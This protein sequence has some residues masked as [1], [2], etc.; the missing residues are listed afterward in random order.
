MYA[1]LDLHKEYS[2]AVVLDIDGT[3]LREERLENEDPEEMERFSESLPADTDIVIESSSTWYWVHRMLSKKHHVVLSNPLKTKAIA[4]AKLK[5]D[6]VDALMLANLLRGGYIAES[7]V[8][9]QKTMELRELVR[10][11]ANLV[12]MRS[13]LKNRIHALLLMNNIRVDAGPFTKEFLEKVRTIEDVKVQGYPRLIDSVNEEIRNAS[14]EVSKEAMGSEEARLLMT[15]PG[16]S[17][18]SALLIAS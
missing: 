12:R 18:Y 1:A 8:P 9:T 6:R 13:D 16:I 4:S 15:V 11:R 3:I 5:T 14:A 2:Q 10:Y 17:F 7:Y